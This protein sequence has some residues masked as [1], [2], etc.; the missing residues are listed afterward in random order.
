MKDKSGQKS[1]SGIDLRWSVSEV[2]S[3]DE[4]RA[5]DFYFA[6]SIVLRR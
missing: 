1:W 3:L 4:R 5:V 2:K 6:T